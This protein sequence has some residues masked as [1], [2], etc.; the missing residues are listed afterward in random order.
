MANRLQGNLRMIVRIRFCHFD[1]LVDL[2]LSGPFVSS[3]T[4]RRG[5][6]GDLFAWS[7]PRF[8]W[9]CTTSAKKKR[10]SRRRKTHNEISY[11]RSVD[12]SFGMSESEREEHCVSFLLLSAAL[13]FFF[14]HSYIYIHLCSIIRTTEATQRGEWLNDF[15]SRSRRRSSSL[16]VRRQNRSTHT[17]YETKDLFIIII[18]F[19]LPLP[20]PLLAACRFQ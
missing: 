8:A 17:Q 14:L 18:V 9:V 12:R 2:L 10:T 20:S 1:R 6:D 7:F 13:F 15:F 5:R 11:W 3:D 4:V 16:S 19:L